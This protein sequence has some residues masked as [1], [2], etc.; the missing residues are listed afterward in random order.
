MSVS[1]SSKVQ[2]WCCGVAAICIN[3][4]IPLFFQTVWSPKWV[5][6]TKNAYPMA[7][8][9]VWTG[10]DA[11]LAEAS[12]VFINYYGRTVAALLFLAVWF[13]IHFQVLRWLFRIFYARQSR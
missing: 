3:L 13:F 5:Q 7:Q 2:L 8:A 12:F 9:G 1:Q 4:L 10:W 11:F 6:W